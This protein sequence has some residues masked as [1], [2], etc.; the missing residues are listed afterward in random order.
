MSEAESKGESL[1]YAWC[2]VYYNEYP[3]W[4]NE[5][6]PVLTRCLVL[7]D[8]EIEQ[9]EDYPVQIWLSFVKGSR[10][11]LTW[12]SQVCDEK[13]FRKQWRVLSL[14]YHPDH[15]LGGE[16]TKLFGLALQ[17]REWALHLKRFHQKWSTPISGL[18]YVVSRHSDLYETLFV[19]LK[20]QT[21]GWVSLIDLDIN[22]PI[23]RYV[24]MFVWSVKIWSPKLGVHPTVW[25]RN[26]NSTGNWECCLDNNLKIYH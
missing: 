12:Q 10:D 14:R 25:I 7:T 15:N 5:I 24:A 13:Q 4:E 23:H 6:L 16:A 9:Q 1:L 20:R 17:I 3:N 11:F 19:A 22:L 2:V 26:S 18:L 8:H 21:S